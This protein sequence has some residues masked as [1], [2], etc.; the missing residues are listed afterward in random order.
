MRT[1]VFALFG[2]LLLHCLAANGQTTDLKNTSPAHDDGEEL[3]ILEV[4][5]ATNWNFSGGAATFAPNFAA[6]CTP[7]EHWLELEAGVSPFF[8][9][10]S[11]LARRDRLSGSRTAKG[12]SR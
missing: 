11:T 10:R 5:A 3:V 6:E 7:I 2:V 8:T 1:G 4:G 9:R 12:S